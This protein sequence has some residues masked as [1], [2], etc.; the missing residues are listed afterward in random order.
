MRK[1]IVSSL[2]GLLLALVGCSHARLTPVR[3]PD[4]TEWIAIDCTHGAKNC[5]EAA[6]E[7]CPN[8][9]QTADEVQS[10]RGFLLFR[11]SHDEMLVHCTAPVAVAAPPVTPR[12]PAPPAQ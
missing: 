5:W 3:G 8:G 6:A 7:F 9:Y 12:A 2:V 4:G 1:V 10:S 11:H